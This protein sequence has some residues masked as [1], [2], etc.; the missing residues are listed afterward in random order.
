M[1]KLFIFMVLIRKARRRVN[2]LEVSVYPF[3]EA[4]PRVHAPAAILFLE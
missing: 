2:A 4:E 1:C 3:E